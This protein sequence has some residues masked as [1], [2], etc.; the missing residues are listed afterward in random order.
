[1]GGS[2]KSSSKA[3]T[4]PAAAAAAAAAASTEKADV[5]E[6]PRHTCLHSQLH[7]TKFCLYHLKG[8]CQFGS[9]CSFAHSCAELQ[10]TPDLRKT[11]LCTAFFEGGGCNDET[12]TFAHSEED[13]R[14]TDMFFKK[15]LCIWN[16]KGKCRNGEQCRFA[17]G[18]HELRLNTKG[19]EKAV[20]EE[21][22]GK[23]NL[24]TNQD[25]EDMGR[26]VSDTSQVTTASGVTTVSQVTQA[27]QMTS[28]S[29]MTTTSGNGSTSGSLSGNDSSTTGTM[30]LTSGR[31]ARARGKRGAGVSAGTKQGQPQPQPA[32]AAAS[33]TPPPINQG[34]PGLQ[35]TEQPLPMKVLLN[36]QN[37]EPP[38]TDPAP[39]AGGLTAASLSRLNQGVY[40]PLLEAELRRLRAS[41]NALAMQCSQIN[42]QINAE[43]LVR[44]AAFRQQLLQ[45]AQA[46]FNQSFN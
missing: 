31:R 37:I 2:K 20:L 27:S 43:A 11:R 30:S 13:L 33:S 9:D 5:K 36:R 15:T 18:V 35:Q 34:P 39:V 32:A 23:D 42:D 26:Q 21:D 3:A 28:G 8:A 4:K 22:D 12:C 40:D 6:K 19:A 29:Q 10:A 17:H 16:E 44:H 1:M 46:R 38:R 41:V 24:N 25:N 14:S 45:L 7:K